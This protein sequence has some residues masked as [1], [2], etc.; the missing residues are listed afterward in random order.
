VTPRTSDLLIFLSLLSL[1]GCQRGCARRW[2]EE[3]SAEKAAPGGPST[4]AMNA[5]DCPDGLARCS[6]GV[7]QVSR[8]A[9]IPLPCTGPVEHCTCPWERATECELACAVDDV[10]VVLEAAKAGRQLC[11]PPQDATPF[12]RAMHAAAT[13]GCDEEELYRC[14]AGAV[15]ACAEKAV[16]ATCVRGCATEGGSVGGEGVVSREAAFAILCSR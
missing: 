8:L 6:G 2:V 15:V 5:I 7:V 10:E 3:R 11:A 14:A 16:V 13:V 4:P 9:S 12:V 1:S